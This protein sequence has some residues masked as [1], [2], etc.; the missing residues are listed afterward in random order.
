MADEK[1][2]A[3][4]RMQVAAFHSIYRRMRRAEKRRSKE[5]DFAE[6]LVCTSDDALAGVDKDMVE[7]WIKQ[8]DARN[9]RKRRKQDESRARENVMPVEAQMGSLDRP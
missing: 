9:A 5:E 6:A 2:R 3:R 7:Q 4:D 8:Y 1:T